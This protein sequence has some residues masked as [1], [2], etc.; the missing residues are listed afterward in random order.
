MFREHLHFSWMLAVKRD[1][2]FFNSKK[3]NVLKTILGEKA[4]FCFCLGRKPL[5]IVTKSS[6]L[7]LCFYV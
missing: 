3:K 1:P 5:T 2:C 6:I 7:G 4:E